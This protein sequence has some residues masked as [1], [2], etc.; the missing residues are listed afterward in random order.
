MTKHKK[1]IPHHNKAHSD[2]LILVQLHGRGK[3]I[4]D[5]M[6]WAL[7]LLTTQLVYKLIMIRKMLPESHQEPLDQNLP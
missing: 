1:E 4:Y 6:P 3:L 7:C 2:H 5:S